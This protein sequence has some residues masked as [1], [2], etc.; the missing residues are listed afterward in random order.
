MKALNRILIKSS[1]TAKFIKLKVRIKLKLKKSMSFVYFVYFVSFVSIFPPTICKGDNMSKNYLDVN[2]LKYH[3]YF[4]KNDVLKNKKELKEIRKFA[5]MLVFSLAQ[6]DTITTNMV[7]DIMNGDMDKLD[8]KI[9]DGMTKRIEILE[10]MDYTTVAEAP[11]WPLIRFDKFENYKKT[12]KFLKKRVPQMAKLDYFYFWDEPDINY[13]PGP[14]VMEKYIAEFKKVFPK[15]K[16]TTCYAI[17]KER[18]LDVVPPRNYD[19]LMIDPYFLSNKTRAHTA[20]DF[21]IFYRERLAL[22][23]A[24]VNEQDKPFLMV[25]DAFGSITKEG[26]LFPTPDISL[27]YYMIALTQPKCV[28]LLWFQYGYLKTQEKIS[29]VTID[30]SPKEGKSHFPVRTNKELMKVHREIGGKI[31]GKPSP[32]GVPFEIG[33]PKCSVL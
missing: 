29:G 4:Y 11:F 26:K 9:F 25:G 33:E 18:F 14:K 19:L 24:W 22:A 23:L 17:A 8:P 2:R 28:G 5:N 10:A 27:W 31:F 32:I 13:I 6:Y 15:V 1:K 21:E 12:L 16:V 30:A 3:G 7:T 20:A